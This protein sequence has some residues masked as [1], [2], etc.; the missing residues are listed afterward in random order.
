[1]EA[2]S[3]ARMFGLDPFAVLDATDFEWNLRRA[4]HNI[5]WERI[6][7]R[8]RNNQTDLR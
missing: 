8:A 1:M 3:V 7:Y 2:A 5:E 6:N 4:C